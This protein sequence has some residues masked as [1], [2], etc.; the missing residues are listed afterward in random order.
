MVGE[1]MLKRNTDQIIRKFLIVFASANEEAV[2]VWVDIKESLAF[3][4]VVFNFFV[5]TIPGINYKDAVLSRVE[6]QSVFNFKKA[7]HL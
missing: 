3:Q 4:L 2:V 5:V 7:H 6:I 1:E